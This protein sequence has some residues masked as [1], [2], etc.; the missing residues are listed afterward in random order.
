MSKCGPKRESTFME[1]TMPNAHRTAPFVDEGDDPTLS[2]RHLWRQRDAEERNLGG[3]LV[4]QDGRR[5]ARSSEEDGYSSL[6]YGYGDPVPLD[7][8]FR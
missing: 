7:M 2:L 1:D 4:L 3:E 8:M 6:P 5:L